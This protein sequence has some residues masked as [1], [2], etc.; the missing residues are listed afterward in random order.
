MPRGNPAAKLAISMNQQVHDMVVAA[1]DAD[2]VT[3]SA[4]ITEAARR[5][6]L[7]EDGL[8]AV[9]EF[10]LEY[11][12]FTPEE[13]AEARRQLLKETAARSAKRRKSA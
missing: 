10:E 6:L 8:A 2:G 12:A 4:W 5:R 9:R 13:L 1:A 3:V 7:I 11:G